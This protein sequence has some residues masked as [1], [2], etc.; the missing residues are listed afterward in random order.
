MHMDDVRCNSNVCQLIYRQ[1]ARRRGM[2]RIDETW[3]G[4]GTVNCRTR[5][6]REGKKTSIRR[7]SNS[8]KGVQRRPR[9]GIAAWGLDQTRRPQLD[10]VCVVERCGFSVLSNDRTDEGGNTYATAG[11]RGL[12][13]L[14]S[15]IRHFL[16]SG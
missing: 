15:T 8:Q 16:C 6:I 3:V 10:F 12:S 1:Q 7:K 4:R 5:A 2:L 9:S 13:C 11:L 14:Y